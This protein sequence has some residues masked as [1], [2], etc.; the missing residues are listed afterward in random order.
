MGPS[1]PSRRTTHEGASAA[2]KEAAGE[3]SRRLSIRCCQPRAHGLDSWAGWC[4]QGGDWLGAPE[5]YP[6]HSTRMKRPAIRA[7]CTCQSRTTGVCCERMQAV[8]FP[9]GN[10]FPLPFLGR[11]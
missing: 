8:F 3:E 4:R 10:T 9:T 11:Y 5:S 7:E 1:Y 6:S 2:P